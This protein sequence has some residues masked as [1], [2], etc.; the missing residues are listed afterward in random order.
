MCESCDDPNEISEGEYLSD[1][2]EGSGVSYWVPREMPPPR[3]T[4]Y[5]KPMEQ[6]SKNQIHKINNA[7][8]HEA[9]INRGRWRCLKTG[10]NPVLDAATAEAHKAET[11]HRV[12]A[13]PVRSKE[14]TRRA[15]ARNKSSYYRK[16]N[17]DKPY[18]GRW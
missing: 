8:A 13:W 15:I 11:G 12:A 5:S 7:N 6:L 4:S 14:G 17:I 2:L 16:Y 9:A 3:T 10:C 1:W 18:G